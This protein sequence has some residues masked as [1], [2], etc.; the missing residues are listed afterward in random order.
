[1]NVEITTQPELRAAAVHHVGPYMRISEAFARLGDI[2]G[3]AGL[4]GPDTLMIGVYH[5]DPETTPEQDLRSDAAVTVSP[6]A[7]IPAGLSELVIP[8]GRYARTTHLGP[9]QTLGDTWSR[10]MGEW[11]PRSEYRVGDG[12]SYEVYRNNPMNAKPEELITDIYVP[13]R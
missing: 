12:V 1:M 10:L 3:R 9:Y 5:D 6:S 7:K 2:A 11:L 13:L 8:G 4:F